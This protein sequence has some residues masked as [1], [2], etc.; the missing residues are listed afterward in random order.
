MTAIPVWLTSGSGPFSVT[1]T[2]QTRA[3]DGTLSDGTLVTL[4]GTL[5]DI[6]FENNPKNENI[7]PMSTRRANY[8]PVEDD[9]S[10]TLVEL[11]K[12][13]GTNLLAT[14][15]YTADY[16]KLVVTRGG[17]AYTHYGV[18]G[19]YSE[20]IK[21]GKSVA[22]LVLQPVDIGSANPAYA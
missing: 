11:L 20:S 12:S 22:R 4:T 17:Q 18:R 2:P 5:D 21:N 13:N 6:E 1:L 7:K 16:F 9:P 19:P 8:V 14:A 15:N 3:S 10:W